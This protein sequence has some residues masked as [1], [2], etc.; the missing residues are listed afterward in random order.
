MSNIFI[1]KLNFDV[2][3]IS[4]E[5]DKEFEVSDDLKFIAKQNTHIGNKHEIDNNELKFIS[6]S[7]LFK[8]GKKKMVYTSDVGSSE[9][10]YLFDNIQTDLFITETTHLSFSDIEKAAI[11]LNPAK[12]YLTHI[13]DENKLKNWHNNLFEKDR[14]KFLIAFDGMIVD[15]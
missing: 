7:F 8:V 5:F 12:I 6:S 2:D 9:D 14:E 15:L 13:D 1:E 10:L 11:I 3:L 4:F